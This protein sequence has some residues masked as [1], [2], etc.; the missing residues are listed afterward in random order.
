MIISIKLID[1]FL[2]IHLNLNF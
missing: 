2:I 1:Q